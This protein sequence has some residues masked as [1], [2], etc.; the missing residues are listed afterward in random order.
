MVT[1][2]YRPSESVMHRPTPVKLGSSGAGWLSTAC[3]YRPDAL[4]C[5]ISIRVSGTG[6]RSLSSTWPLRMIRSPSGSPA[7]WVVR[8]ASASA[9]RPSPS[10]GP[11]ISVSRCG[12]RTGGRC[13]ARSA[14]DRYPGESSGGCTPAGRS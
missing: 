9:T 11:V 1:N 2:R 13:G 10:S 4:A 6:R 5:Q 12:A 8:S 7:W 3:R 14:V